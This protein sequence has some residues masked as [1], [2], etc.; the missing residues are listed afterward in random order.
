LKRLNHRSARAFTIVETLVAMMVIVVFAGSA[1]MALTQLNRFATAARLR[2]LAMGIG[3]QRIDEVLTVP[4][5]LGSAAPAVL[6][7]GTRIE[8]N[9]G[10]N[11]DP[12]ATLANGY[13]SAVSTL[14]TDSVRAT[15][16]T[17]VVALTTRTVRATVT[18]AYIYRSRAYLA[19]LTT[20]RTTDSF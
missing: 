20:L 3:Q 12:L 6:Q 5:Q 2:T 14:D 1:L 16:T 13:G 18:V 10:L 7:P 15:R 9:L 8:T 19:Q 17:Q 4:W 11:D